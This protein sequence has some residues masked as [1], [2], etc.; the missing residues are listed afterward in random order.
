MVNGDTTTLLEGVTLPAGTFSQIRFMVDLQETG[1]GAPTTP[2]SY[3]TVDGADTAL[4]VPS[5]GHS[6][7]KA[8]FGGAVDVPA[9]GAVTFVVDWDVRKALVEA[10]DRYILKPTF[11]VV[12]EDEAGRIA[13]NITNP[14]TEPLIVFAYESGTY[15]ESE[16]ATPAGEASWFPGAVSSDLVEDDGTGEFCFQIW[17]L[18]AGEYDF[19]VASFDEVSDTYSILASPI[20]GAANFLADLV[21]I[22]VTPGDLTEGIALTL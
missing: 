14:G 6:G 4:F 5:G 16:A 18:A 15:D 12:V 21:G 13:G 8:V 9:N 1:Q 3:V 2:A 22:I 17:Y 7:Y 20:A 10:G 11:R 19:V